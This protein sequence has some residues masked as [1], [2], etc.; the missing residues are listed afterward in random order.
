VAA[1]AVIV[2][3]CLLA[4]LV[5]A[6]EARAAYSVTI[7]Q[8]TL[9]FTGDGSS[10]KLG[11]RVRKNRP[12]QLEV[13]FGDDGTADLRIR[14]RDFARIHVRAGG[15]HDAVRVLF[16]ERTPT[17]LDGGPG[18]DTL[19]G[20]PGADLI[21]GGSGRDVADG[22]EGTD[23]AFLG[24]GDDRYAWSQGERDDRIDGEAGVDTATFAGSSADEAFRVG[25]AGS[26]TRVTRNLRGVARLVAA[27]RVAVSARGGADSLTV[28]DQSATAVRAF[29]ADLG[30]ADGVADRVIVNGT[31]GRDV[32]QANDGSVNGLV[33]AVSFTAA[34]AGSDQLVVNGLAGDDTITGAGLGA[35]APAFTADGGAGADALSGGPGADTLLGGDGSDRF[36]WRPGDGNDAV[37]GQADQDVL[38]FDGSDD[39]ETFAVTDAALTR[40]IGSVAL[41]L[42]G[43]ERIELL[44]RGGDD[45]VDGSAATI[46]LHLAGGD[47]ADNLKGG[48]GD[49]TLL[50]GPGV[51]TLDGGPGTNTIV[52]D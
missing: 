31:A 4:G 33:T 1:I 39:P 44:A 40:D 37:N 45:V 27:E 51:D 35:A 52:Q 11:M 50:G 48:A 49:D 5:P 9:V 13:D 47:G 38:A 7:Q 43:I 28:D 22:N 19:R 18:N 2:A 30:A 16:T 14:R 20:S 25:R 36:A 32:V 8:R 24:T 17:T 46:A 41:A 29:S 23:L 34:E 3:V 15:G 6:E 12:R 10:E 26:R 21:L 42:A